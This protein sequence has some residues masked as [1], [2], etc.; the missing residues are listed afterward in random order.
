MERGKS[1]YFYR[2]TPT[3]VSLSLGVRV[4][5]LFFTGFGLSAVMGV[6]FNN[7]VVPSLG[8]DA[9]F[10]IL[11]CFTLISFIMLL[12]FRPARYNFIP[13]DGDD[14]EEVRHQPKLRSRKKRAKRVQDTP[15][16]LSE[17]NDRR[18][19]QPLLFVND[20]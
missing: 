3:C 8:W 7:T 14:E 2:L 16:S 20:Q 11:G 10:I 18:L 13:F 1:N 19:K 15:P 5:A 12:F 9:M 17:T 6:V 4:N